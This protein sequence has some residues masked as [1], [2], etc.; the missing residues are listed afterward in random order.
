MTEHQ[1]DHHATIE[2]LF[3]EERTFPPPPGFVDS[4]TY[5][6]PA[7]YDQASADPEAFWAVQA[8]SLTW[9]KKWD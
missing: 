7:I 2:A 9:F 8:E 5:T 3:A 4:A 6:H 1:G